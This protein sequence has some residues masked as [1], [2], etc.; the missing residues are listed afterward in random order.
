MFKFCPETS[1]VAYELTMDQNVGPTEGHNHQ[2]L[3]FENTD[4][5][6]SAQNCDAY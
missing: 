5:K 2:V 4:I 6:S 1:F 3:Y